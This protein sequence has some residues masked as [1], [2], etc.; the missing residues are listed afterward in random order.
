MIVFNN[1]HLYRSVDRF[2]DALAV[3]LDA[4]REF[5]RLSLDPPILV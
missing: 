5:A 2:D 1:A 3:A 4:Y